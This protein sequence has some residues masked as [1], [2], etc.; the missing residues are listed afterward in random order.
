MYNNT[1]KIKNLNFTKKQ[2]H[3]LKVIKKVTTH[4]NKVN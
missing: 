1:N 3:M 2:K 4:D